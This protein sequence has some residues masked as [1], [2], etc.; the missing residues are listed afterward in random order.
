M[1]RPGMSPE[2]IEAALL[3]ENATRCEPPLPEAEVRRIARSIAKY[4]PEAPL[5]VSTPGDSNALRPAFPLNDLGNA[6]RF[7]RD[8]G[9]RLK[10]VGAWKCWMSWDGTRWARA[11]YGVAEALGRETVRK[12]YE[13][14]STIPHQEDRAKFL[15]HLA[16]LESHR[17]FRAMMDLAKTQPGIPQSPTDFDA[18]CHLFNV[19]NGTLDLRTIELRPHDPADF[20]TKISPVV[21]D[22]TARSEEWERVVEAALPDPELRAYFARCVGY[23]LGGDLI[24]DALFF[25]Y[26]PT[27]TMKSTT[28]GAT[29]SMMGD[30]ART[31]EFDTF[32]RRNDVGGTRPGLAKLPGVRMALCAEVEPRR[33]LHVGLV[34]AF[35]GG[36]LV[37]CHGKYQD[38]F[39]FRPQARLWLMANDLPRI[40]HEDEAMWRR[41]KVLPFLTQ[42]TAYDEGLKL[43]LRD[44][45]RNG[46][47]ILNWAL[48]G[49]A[50]WEARER[51]LDEPPQVTVAGDGYRDA[52][53]TVSSFIDDRCE[54][55]PKAFETSSR[56]LEA[57]DRWALERRLDTTNAKALG[58]RL[59]ALG[60]EPVS[61]GSARGWRGLRLLPLQPD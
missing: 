33:A 34:K 40:P 8:H 55:D 12:M 16:D 4:E 28:M 45:V 22:P 20:I 53:D 29:E 10:Y 57:Y 31:T 43:R 5:V 3:F 2:A 58:S 17:G 6:A 13:E 7:A 44:P 24:H 36:D 46:A 47:A 27:G 52:M 61:T 56:L 54:C 32:L 23:S 18:D 60:Y 39:T 48:R 51:K 1:R 59:K 30:Y 14:A 41:L 49:R 19:Q 37:E 11:E 26:G 9:A 25:V 42:V 15:R 50:D 21:Y 35:T 38:P